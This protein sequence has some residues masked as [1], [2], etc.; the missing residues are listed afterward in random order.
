MIRPARMIR[1]LAVAAW[2]LLG[3][4][5][6]GAPQAAEAE[7]AR[8][9][10]LSPPLERITAAKTGD[11][12]EIRAR[13]RL[14]VL[15][16]YDKTRFF[17]TED[18]PH[19]YEYELFRE[20]EKRLNKGRSSKEPRIVVV[21]VPT[22]FDRLIPDLL[23]GKGD[24]IAAGWT[25]TP[26][27]AAQVAFTRPYLE[28]VDEIVV[29]RKGLQRLDSLADLAGRQVHVLRASSY[30]EHLRR[31]NN[32][33]VESGDEPVRVIEADPSL[34]TEDLLE[35]VNAGIVDLTVADRHIAAIWAQVLE[36]IELHEELIVNAGGDIAWA[37]RPNNPK[38]LAELNEY[39]EVSKQGTLLGNILFKR[40]YESRKWISNPLTEEN[41]DRLHEVFALIQEYSE[42][43]DLDWHMVAAL[44][45]RE[46]RL[47]HSVR[48]K[49]GA[50][51]IMQ[52]TPI[53]ARDKSV[54]IDNIEKLENNIHAGVKLLAALRDRYS[55]D[56]DLSLAARTDFA[57]AA[58]NA[59][60]ANVS[61]MRKRALKMGF[62][63]DVWFDHVEWAA[64]R[65]VGQETVRY[66]ADI[67]KYYLAYKL[68]DQ[69]L[70][71]RMSK[72]EKM[73]DGG[74]VE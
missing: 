24:I 7:E 4:V 10:V 44:A 31:L 49:A 72:R 29:G 64:L 18:G 65:T 57:L 32:D 39:I 46:S 16:T 45:Y 14:R 41:L 56:V 17:V 8:S 9:A 38:L 47:D 22:T 53:A 74:G 25:V 60:P 43:Y 66:V 5:A 34:A 68:S 69:L 12:D 21:F 51:G 42:R 55:E 35:I 62:R 2:V 36:H 23:D 71:R 20:F 73:A 59:G 58:Y 52:V 1:I 63:D 19:G 54:N 70:R 6:R 40:Y 28:D 33:L 26:E 11:L 50:I 13:R 61:R 37:V 48:S 67:H 30:A 15:V 27:R 3:G